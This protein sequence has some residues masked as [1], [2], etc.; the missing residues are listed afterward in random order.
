MATNEEETPK[1]RVW[2]YLPLWCYVEPDEDGGEGF[3]ARISDVEDIIGIGDTPQAAASDLA[4]NAF[5][6]LRMV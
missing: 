3:V 5:L 4:A 2:Y 6:Q 1:W